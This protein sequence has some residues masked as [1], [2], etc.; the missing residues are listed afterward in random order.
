V[1]TI[2][3]SASDARDQGARGS[4]SHRDGAGRAESDQPTSSTRAP[5]EAVGDRTSS[6]AP[7]VGKRGGDEEDQ[8]AETRETDEKSGRS[9]VSSNATVRNDSSNRGMTGMK[10]GQTV[11]IS[12]DAVALRTLS[13]LGLIQP[14]LFKPARYHD[15][16]CHILSH[17]AI[18]G[19]TLAPAVPPARC[20]Y[21]SDLRSRHGVSALP[22]PPS[23]RHCSRERMV[24]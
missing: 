23:P 20:W 16:P 21:S 8:P 5:T 7:D 24:G 3:G 1:T 4:S 22:P 19:V 2:G 14:R 11:E 10:Q 18:S 9:F 12:H 6:H 15:R 17:P 13:W